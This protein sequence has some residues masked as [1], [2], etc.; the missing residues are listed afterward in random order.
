MLSQFVT[1]RHLWQKAPG[2]L[3]RPL[4]SF[5]RD[6][7]KGGGHFP[8]ALFHSIIIIIIFYL[9]INNSKNNIRVFYAQLNIILYL[10]KTLLTT[11]KYMAKYG[12][13]FLT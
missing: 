8:A 6:R 2:R 13:T 5:C 12:I 10:W 11:Q 3:R 4:R 7:E 1:S 9:L